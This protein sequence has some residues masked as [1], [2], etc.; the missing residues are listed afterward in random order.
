MF[1]V[2]RFIFVKPWVFVHLNIFIAP[3]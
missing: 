1:R 2:E 3:V